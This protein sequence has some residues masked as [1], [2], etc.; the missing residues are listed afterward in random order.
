MAVDKDYLKNKLDI[1]LVTYNRTGDL[2]NT[3]KQ[4]FAVDSPIKNL[5]VTILDNCSTD[6]TSELI[7]EYKNKY[8]NITHLRNSINIGG[9][10]NI[11]R[12]FE[13]AEK[14]YV[15]V[16]C[17]DDSYNWSGWEE[18]ENAVKDDYDVIF[19]RKTDNTLADIY[20]SATFVPA[21]IYKTKNITS[22]TYINAIDNI[23]NMFPQCAFIA[24]NINDNNRIYIPKH[25]FVEIGL[26]N[27][28]IGTYIRGCNSCEVP[29]SR[30]EIFWAVGYLNSVELITDRKKQIE[31]IDGL[32][33]GYSSLFHFFTAKIQLN[34][35]IYNSS[36]LN[37]YSMFKIL[38]AKQ[39]L[40]F[41]IALIYVQIRYLFANTYFI[42]L[43]NNR[44]WAEYFQY[45]SEQK[46]INKLVKKYRN[47][48]IL[49]Y[50]TGTIADILFN[51]YDLSGLEIT[52]VSD[53]K[54][55]QAAKY[56]NYP[57]IPAEQIK[58]YN[59]EVI[60]F[61]LYREK[62]AVKMLRSL[63]INSKMESLIKR[64]YNVVI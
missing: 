46:Y 50:G 7:Q 20:Y 23:R 25:Q 51:N 33:H 56:K 37:L 15:W 22:T 16:I 4:I 44:K 18:I 27:G 2:E 31:I 26:H 14:D 12:A 48:K 29:K 61:T 28:G 52:A 49:I 53:K 13:L 19:T 47:K 21:C 45:I 63:G 58:E 11:A 60:L 42:N 9:N 17:D 8:S 39:R 43:P 24:K 5:D 55:S 57:A 38:S 54:Y 1:F 41:I 10:A 40:K 62:E 34:R 35:L 32:R 59:P 30:A 36:F 3:L 64:V 6:G